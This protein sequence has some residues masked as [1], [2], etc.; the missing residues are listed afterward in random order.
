MPREDDSTEKMRYRELRGWVWAAADTYTAWPF[1]WTIEKV[2][3]SLHG[4]GNVLN[5]LELDTE[6]ILW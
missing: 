4:S 3:Y 1:F 2:H 6:R 5:D